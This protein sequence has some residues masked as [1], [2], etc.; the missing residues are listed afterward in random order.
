MNEHL[1][2]T[3]KGCSPNLFHCSSKC[4][5]FIVFGSRSM[6]AHQLLRLAIKNAIR[7]DSSNKQAP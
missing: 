3:C 2:K 4:C 5:T 7:T 1:N 6:E